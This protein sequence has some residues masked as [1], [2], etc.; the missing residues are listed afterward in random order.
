MTGP[1][2]FWQRLGERPYDFD[3]FAALRRIESLHPQNPRLGHSQRPQQDP[4]RLGQAPST[5]FAPATL[6]GLDERRAAAKLR[7]FSFGL[8][9][10][11]GPLPLAL[12][13]YA[14]ERAN[15]HGDET[16]SAFADIFHHRLI[17]LFYR[18]W[19]SAQ[20]TVSLDRDQDDSFT[21]HVASLVHHGL[22]SQRERDSVPDH[23]RWNHAGHLVRQ[24]RN[25]EGLERILANFFRMP[26]RIE[27]FAR[28]WLPLP[29]DQRTRLG[30]TS[31]AQLGVDAVAG[32]AVPDR[33][34]R[35]R[36]RLGAMGLADYENLLPTGRGHRQLL[37]WARS[38]IGI[39]YA[40]DVRLVLRAAEVPRV[41][42]GGGTRLGWTSWLGASAATQDR[43]DLVL[44]PEHIAATT[45]SYRPQ[46][47]AGSPSSEPTRSHP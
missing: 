28:H 31:N 37:D 20:S 4:I 22:E 23:A 11:N 6:A 18:A 19:A 14:M 25:A 5:S 34:H 38:Y 40:W 43:D 41:S 42:L 3:L 15:H 8:F 45:H 47:T 36:I 21:R 16:L 30:G 46:R 9:G 12:T 17:Q 32:Q 1:S 24:V 44:D 29:D 13:E 10:P 27:E 2:D 33:Q 7:I 26:A 35:F 39:E